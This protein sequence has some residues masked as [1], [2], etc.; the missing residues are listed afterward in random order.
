MDDRQT[1][2]CLTRLTRWGRV[3]HVLF[4]LLVLISG[5]GCSEQAEGDEVAT[6][7]CT[8]PP[9]IEFPSDIPT[10]FPWP[11]EVSVTEARS[12]KGFVSLEGFTTRSVDELFEGARPELVANGFDV[13]NS[14][15][16]GF[17]AELYFAKGDSLAGIVSMR[18]GPCDG[19]V[20][21]NVLYDPLE[22]EA[23]RDAV[24]KTRKLSGED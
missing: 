21:V 14:D 12:Q 11:Q 3:S 4:S 18:E 17:E 8:L 20:K 19:Y 9:T 23:G 15:F 10:D 1:A 24:K 6:P 22:T 2:L 7:T 5:A 13:I 16:E